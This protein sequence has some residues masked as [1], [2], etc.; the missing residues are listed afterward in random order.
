MTS[1]I[2]D[3]LRQHAN[4]EH[5]ELYQIDL[6]SRGGSVLFLSPN[7]T[8]AGAVVFNGNTY[9]PM[10][11]TMSAPRV[12]T[13]GTLPQPQLSVGVTE[14]ALVR[15]A[16]VAYGDLAGVPVTRFSTR[17]KYLD[18]ASFNRINALNYSETF[19]AAIWTKTGTTVTPDATTAPDGSGTADAIFETATTAQHFI[20]TVKSFGTFQSGDW[21]NYSCYIKYNGTPYALLYASAN[22]GGGIGGG[23]LIDT[24]TGA[25]AAYN[26]QTNVF[27]PSSVDVGGGWFKVSFTSTTTA[28]GPMSIYLSATANGGAPAYAGNAANGVY[29]WGAQLQKVDSVSVDAATMTPSGLAT[30][31]LNTATQTDPLGGTTSDILADTT[32]VSGTHY[33]SQ[34]VSGFTKGQRVTYTT[35]CRAGSVLTKVMIRFLA[36]TALATTAYANID[37]ST[38]SVMSQSNLTQDPVIKALTNGWYRISI[39]IDTTADGIL[40]PA[41]M[42]LNA[43]NTNTYVGTGA[44]VY[45]WFGSLSWNDGLMP[46][47]MTTTTHQPY[48]DPTATSPVDRFIV[49][50]LLDF[51]PE[52]VTWKLCTPIDRPNLRLPRLQYLPDPVGNHIWVPGMRRVQ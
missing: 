52:T 3:Y 1:L 21:V 4:D 10:P 29:L 48:A 32:G 46:Y 40:N 16:L 5:V 45:I 36:S 31:T 30:I 47:Q 22:S 17:T 50:Q 49:S 25:I 44:G 51:G 39:T 18:E 41:I 26:N 14:S 24:Q 20:T 8:D 27:N 35:H 13:T 19:N 37:L 7:V 42:L 33:A 38:G 9:T 28:T 23:V 6:T 12:G 34:N 2:T 43:A 11:I 15:A